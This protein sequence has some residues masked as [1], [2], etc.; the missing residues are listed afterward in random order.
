M[1]RRR[2]I[3]ERGHGVA[4]GSALADGGHGLD[5]AFFVVRL[6]PSSLLRPSEARAAVF[7]VVGAF[8]ESATPVRER[9]N[10]FEIVTG[11]LDPDTPFK[12]H[13]HLVRL[14]LVPRE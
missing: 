11:M 12:T 14:E 9:G 8:A 2:D 1:D 13:G 3:D 5:G 7:S 6:R 4:N 10:R